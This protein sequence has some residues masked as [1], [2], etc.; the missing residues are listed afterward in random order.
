MAAHAEGKE[1]TVFIPR[2][3]RTRLGKSILPGLTPRSDFEGRRGFTTNP[4]RPALTGCVTERQGR[5]VEGRFAASIESDAK[6]R[7]HMYPFRT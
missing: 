6:K 5:R 4:A 3:R 1:A 2:G 7:G